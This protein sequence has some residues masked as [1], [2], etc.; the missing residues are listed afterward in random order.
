MSLL[1]NT[2]QPENT[3]NIS[4]FDKNPARNL[5]RNYL[6]KLYLKKI[7]TNSDNI[8]KNLGTYTNQCVENISDKDIGLSAT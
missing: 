4:F 2:V 8:F 3:F 7:I 6:S 5:A 1:A